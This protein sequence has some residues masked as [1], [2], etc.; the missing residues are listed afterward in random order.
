MPK[1]NDYKAHAKERGALAF[2][3]FAVETTPCAPPE[4][5]QATLPDHL[6]YQKELEAA[7]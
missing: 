2:E 6:S 3:L 4:Q 7:G 5:M 1:W